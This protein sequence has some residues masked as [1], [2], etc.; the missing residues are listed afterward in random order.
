MDQST[1]A[2][3]EGFF[4]FGLLIVFFDTLL[5]RIDRAGTWSLKGNNV[6]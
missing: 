5:G 6:C 4:V 3:V 2:L 1:R